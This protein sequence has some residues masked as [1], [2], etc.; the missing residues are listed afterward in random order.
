[1]LLGNQNSLLIDGKSISHNKIGIN[2]FKNIYKNHEVAVHTLTHPNLTNLDD[3][4][5]IEQVEEDRQALSKLIN[6][7][8]VGMAYPCGGVNNDDYVAG[9]IINNTGVKYSRTITSNYSFDMQN[10]LY[11]F[12]PTVYHCELE[13]MFELGEKFIKLKT[14]KP[15]IYYIWGHSYELDI[16]GDWETFEGFCKLISNQNDIYYGTNKKILLGDI[17]I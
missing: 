5:I 13:K 2:E 12:N 11:R 17:S 4:E 6:Y 9:V 7:E 10:N 8:V 1:M 16:N 14:D 15:Q 3:K